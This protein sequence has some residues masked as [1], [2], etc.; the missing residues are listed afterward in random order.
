MT[1]TPAY[2][3][4]VGALGVAWSGWSSS[5]SSGGGGGG[6]PGIGTVHGDGLGAPLPS[7]AGG[8]PITRTYALHQSLLPALLVNSKSSTEILCCHNLD[9]LN[10][11]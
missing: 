9:N 2:L 1:Q 11:M 8:T 3:A 5:Q 7:G 4:E 10:P 6:P